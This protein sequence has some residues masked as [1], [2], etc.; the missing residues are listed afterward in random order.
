VRRDNTNV[1]QEYSEDWSR[2]RERLESAR[3]LDEWLRIPGIDDVADYYN[4]A[5]RLCF[6]AFDS[7]RFYRMTLLQA[8]QKHFPGARTVAEFGAGIGR[9]L[10]FL[11]R[12]RPELGL[13]GYE[14]CL[15]GVDVA[16]AAATKFGLDVKYAQ[17]D[18]LNDADDKYIFPVTDVAFTMFSL[19]QLPRDNPQAVRNILNHVRLGSLHIEPVPENYPLSVRGLLGR[20]DHWKVD[21]LSRFDCAVRS[22]GLRDVMVESVDSAH[23]PLMF[24]SLYILRRA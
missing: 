13:Y 1:V 11:K 14:L 24:P 15:A 23:N 5:G 4:V 16:R 21:Y 9:N 22:L 8:I 20:I 3:S 12:E 18:Y 19:E 17:L 6:E 7:P 2:Y 10:L